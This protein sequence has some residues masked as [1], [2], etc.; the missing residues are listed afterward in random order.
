LSDGQQYL[1]AGGAGFQSANAVMVIEILPRTAGVKLGA[2]SHIAIQGD[3]EWR[4]GLFELR[5]G[6]GDRGFHMQNNHFCLRFRL[7]EPPL[8]YHFLVV[9]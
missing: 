8:V 9:L 7:K 6:Q 2:V 3:A 4:F 5:P 1:R